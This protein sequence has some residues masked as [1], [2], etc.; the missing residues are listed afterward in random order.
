MITHRR[1]DSLR[2]EFQILLFELAAERRRILD[3]VEDFFEQVFCDFGLAAIRLCNF[4]DLLANHGLAALRLDDDERLLAGIDVIRCFCNLEIARGQ[5]AMAARRAA[6]FDIRDLER[7][8]RVIEQRDNPADRADELEFE[9]APAH[10]VREREAADEVRKHRFQKFRR[11]LALFVHDGVDIAVFLHEVFRLHMLAACEALCRLRRLA[12]CVERDLDGRTAVLTRNIGL[13]FRHTVDE[14]C[15]TARR[16]ERL[17][18]FKLDARVFERRLRLFL[19]LGEDA[20]HHMGRN[21]L[22]ADFKQ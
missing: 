9:R 13:F 2:R 12:I 11:L 4:L 19:Q 7:D 16:A 15:R 21:F 10:V 14:Q 18:A 3:E 22:R 17:D 6:G 20:R 8:D 5:E 1:D